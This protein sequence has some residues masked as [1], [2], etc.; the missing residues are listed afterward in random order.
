M[1]ATPSVALVTG[2][3]RG[4]GRGIALELARLGYAVA[5]NYI[6][7]RDAAEECK[8]LCQQA[9][10]PG[11]KASFEVFQA[12]ISLPEDRARLLETVRERFEWIDLLVNNAGVAPSPR[13]DILQASEESFDRIFAINLKGP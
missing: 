9:A 1:H 2:A 13:A 6:T 3:S 5:I 8:T 12:D 4:I 10:P 11:S 7:H